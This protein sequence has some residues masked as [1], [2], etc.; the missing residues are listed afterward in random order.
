MTNQRPGIRVSAFTFAFHSKFSLMLRYAGLFCALL[1]TVF[2]APTALSQ[3]AGAG[4]ITGTVTDTSNALV[5]SAT[6]T[7]T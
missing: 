5:T 6:V 4:T 3:T 2:G 7:I 1:L